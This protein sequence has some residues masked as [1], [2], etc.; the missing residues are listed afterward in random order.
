[1]GL[2]VDGT[3]AAMHEMTVAGRRFAPKPYSADGDTGFTFHGLPGSGTLEVELV[4]EPGPLRLRLADFDSD[5]GGLDSL[6]TY[7]PPGRD[8]YLALADTA[9][10]RT[11]AL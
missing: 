11:F 7:R 5:T 9:V 3:S 2:Y 10:S 8:R 6:P 1:M 4:V